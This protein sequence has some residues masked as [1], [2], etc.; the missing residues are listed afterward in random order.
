MP[1]NDD[2]AAFTGALQDATIELGDFS[3]GLGDATEAATDLGD[4]GDLADGGA[5]A[6]SGL[7]AGLTK[8]AGA[9]AGGGGLKEIAQVLL[10]IASAGLPPGVGTVLTKA[11]GSKL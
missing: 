10:G 3:D 2:F 4:L 9:V 6:G 5:E 1:A 8:V 7:P 11:V